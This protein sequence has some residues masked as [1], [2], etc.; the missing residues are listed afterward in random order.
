MHKKRNVKL[1]NDLRVQPLFAG[2]SMQ[3]DHLHPTFSALRLF[4]KDLPYIQADSASFDA[5]FL[6]QSNE[7]Q[8]SF[9]RL[10]ILSNEWTKFL[11]TLSNQDGYCMDSLYKDV[12][13]AIKGGVELFYSGLNKPSYK[14]N[15]MSNCEGASKNLHSF[16]LSNAKNLPNWK[17]WWGEDA[18][19]FDLKR[20]LD[21]LS[22]STLADL[23]LQPANFD[24]VYEKISFDVDRQLLGKI[25][26]EISD[27]DNS[28]PE[29]ENLDAQVRYINH[30]TV[31]VKRGNISVMVDPLLNFYDQQNQISLYDY[32]P[33]SIDYVLITHAHYD[34]I[35]LATLLTLR[36]RIGKILLPRAS[37]VE[38]D[39]SL[40]KALEDYFPGKVFEV[41]SF[42]TLV[43]AEG[44]SITSLPFQGEHSDLI[45]PKSTWLIS[46]SG[47]N[48]WFGADSRA[49]DISLHKFIRN[50]YGP[51]DQMFIGT[52]CEGSPLNRAYPHFSSNTSE[53]NCKSRTT[54]GADH[55]EIY[56]M[57]NALNPKNVYIYALG[58]E[59]WLN[60]FLGDPIKRY[61]E[62]FEL[63]TELLARKNIK[64][65]NLSMLV[66]P[67]KLGT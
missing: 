18:L 48:L 38:S 23:V 47:K 20:P 58:F 59:K 39:F 64:L 65:K 42:E 30:A 12:P 49:I 63:L 3:I 37:V 62:E 33:N 16:V 44:F 14:L 52:V 61:I 7:F 36:N 55:V 28:D 11:E 57:I 31:V 60:F 27:D 56:E 51:L 66:N 32:A 15:G 67:Q 54:K 8:G 6:K 22:C 53:E 34:H 19:E 43:V 4:R 5:W 9:K 26:N 21:H 25:T 10:E 41:D 13:V 17:Y 29:T 35:D 40:K 46:V 1:R 24:E 45:S 50:K 2:F